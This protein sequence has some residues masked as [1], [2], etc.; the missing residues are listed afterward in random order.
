MTCLE[1]AALPAIFL[2][3]TPAPLDKHSPRVLLPPC[4]TGFPLSILRL[5]RLGT[6]AEIQAFPVRNRPEH[7]PSRGLQCC[8]GSA[9][10]RSERFCARDRFL[11]G[12]HSILQC[13]GFFRHPAFA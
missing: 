11:F 7:F 3:A 9:R 10:S 2:K 12:P 6:T 5:R 8:S 1:S 4:S 13:A